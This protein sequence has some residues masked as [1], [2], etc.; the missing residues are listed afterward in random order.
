MCDEARARLA[1]RQ[2]EL[3]RA[4]YGG[5]PAAGLDARMVALTSAALANKRARAVAR[6]WPAL[7]RE[8][9]TDFADRFRAYA[10]ATAPPDGGA[11]ADGLAFSQVLARDCPLRGDARIEHMAATARVRLRHHRL[12]SRRG[13]HLAAAIT[14]R[15]RRLVIVVSFPPTGTRLIVLGRSTRWRLSQPGRPPA[16]SP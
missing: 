13:P 2:A 4:L 6:A 3:I 10:L 8:L 5:P 16:N 15:P 7:A 11:L 9:G 14:G 12:A 1:A